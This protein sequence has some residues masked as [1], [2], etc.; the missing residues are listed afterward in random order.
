MK[1]IILSL[2]AI[3]ILGCGGGSDEAKKLLQRILKLVGIPQSMVVTICQDTNRDGLCNIGELQ[4]KVN[5]DK[6]DKLNDI[7]EKLTQN[8]DGTY[9]LDN[10]DPNNPIL[11]VLKDEVRIDPIYDNSQFGLSFD[12][13]T[14]GEYFSH[15]KNRTIPMKELSILQSMIDAGQL[16]KSDVA[17]ARTM[18]NVDD[19][20]KVLLDDY[21]INVNTLRGKSLN[22]KQ[23][24]N[25]NIKEMAEELLSN[26]IRDKLPKDMNNCNGDKTCIDNVLRPVSKELLIT[27]EEAEEIVKEQ[28]NSEDENANNQPILSKRDKLLAKETRYNSDGTVEYTNTYKYNNKNKIINYKYINSYEDTTCSSS[29]DT[30]GRISS[31]KC[32][33]NKNNTTNKTEYFYSGNRLSKVEYYKN[34]KISYREKVTE[35]SGEK[36][37]KVERTSYNNRNEEDYISTLLISYDGKNPIKLE[38]I[39]KNNKDIIT[40]KY[41]NKKLPYDIEGEFGSAYYWNFGINNVIEE[42]MITTSNYNNETFTS[43]T[44]TKNSITYNSSDL[45]IRIDTTII[46]KYNGEQQYE[47]NYYTIYEYKDAVK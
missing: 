23:T 37:K 46:S 44:I 30:K 8:P 39:Y 28:T 11:L 27:D 19:F 29:Y 24:M 15:D 47:E 40:K 13:S 45:P 10:Y 38:E 3:L 21:A 18:K 20:Y 36:P 1:K 31:V 34:N 41:D 14:D 9:F 6:G 25:G 17:L 4:T 7:L 42:K 22:A 5:I 32:I 35:W 16:T 43:E 26:G 33:D 2:S 12:S